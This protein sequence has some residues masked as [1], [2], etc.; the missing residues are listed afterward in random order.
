MMHRLATAVAVAALSLLALPAS[1]QFVVPTSYTATPGEGTGSGGSFNYFDDPATP[2]GPGVQLTD[3]IIGTDDWTANLG[4][5]S[6]QEWVGWLTQ[7]PTASFSF[8]APATVTQV[9]I[10]FNRAEGAGIFLP[11][12]VNVNGQVFALTGTEIANGT[13]GFLN[14]DVNF[15]GTTL[16]LTL[17]DGNVNRWIFVDEVRFVGAPVTVPEPSALPLVVCGFGVIGTMVAVRRKSTG[18]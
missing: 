1:A 6:A 11:S 5:G 7:D 4:N 17:S 16:P 18:K 10:G 8:A 3:D 12:N 13:R 15:T 2:G 9:Q 14:F